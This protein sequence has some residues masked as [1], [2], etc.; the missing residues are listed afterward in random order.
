[1]VPQKCIIYSLVSLKRFIKHTQS[2]INYQY[3][4]IFTV[5]ILWVY[6]NPIQVAIILVLCV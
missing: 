6:P 2:G 5:L 3:N 4:N 1:M